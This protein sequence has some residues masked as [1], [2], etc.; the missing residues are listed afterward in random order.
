MYTSSFVFSAWPGWPIIYSRFEFFRHWHEK[1]TW[2]VITAFVITQAVRVFDV[3]AFVSIVFGMAVVVIF[4]ILATFLFLSTLASLP[5]SYLYPILDHRH[6]LPLLLWHLA[7]WGISTVLERIR[8]I[9][10]LWE[11]TPWP[12]F[13]FISTVHYT[14]RSRHRPTPVRPSRHLLY[15]LPG[16]CSYLVRATSFS[17]ITSLSIAAILHLDGLM[18][19]PRAPT[20]TCFN[21][22]PSFSFGVFPRSYSH[23][24]FKLV[25]L[26][27]THD[28]LH[29]MSSSHHHP[30]SKYHHSWPEHSATQWPS[31]PWVLWH[32]TAVTWGPLAMAGGRKS[33]TLFRHPVC[34]TSDWDCSTRL[35]LRWYVGLPGSLRRTLPGRHQFQQLSS[36]HYYHSY[37]L[38]FE[39]MSEM[40]S[41]QSPLF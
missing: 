14:A 34:S 30:L 9:S 25:S 40:I 18:A 8:G 12:L 39:P 16:Q 29:K 11:H 31:F 15:R 13:L 1:S 2:F 17:S 24:P 38:Y 19:V 35:C 23:T 7:L 22:P 10:I 6:W 5:P 32:V 27:R 26:E 21:L 33:Q 4:A 41:R 3:V 36:P 37:H 28:N 20:F